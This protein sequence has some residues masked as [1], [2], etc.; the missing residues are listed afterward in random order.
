[1]AGGEFVRTPSL[2]VG[3]GTSRAVHQALSSFFSVKPGRSGL[4]FVLIHPEDPEAHVGV[5]SLSELIGLS[6]SIARDGDPIQ[7]DC[8]YLIP[9][10]STLTLESGVFRVAPADGDGVERVIDAF[11]HSLAEDRQAGAIGVVLS[12]NGSDGTLGLK[13]ISDAGGMTIVQDPATTMYDGMPRSGATLGMADRVLSPERMVPEILTYSNHLQS[14][15]VGDQ[16]GVVEEQIGGS[17]G[18]I[19]ELLESRTGHNFKHYKTST[20]ARRIGRRMQILRVQ[21]AESYLE[22]LE[23][24]PAEVQDLF[25]E[26]LICVTCFF[27]DP[28]S[29]ERLRAEVI[30]PLLKS[31][32]G[33]DPVRVWVPGCATGEEAYSLAILFREEMDRCPDPPPV[34]IFATDINARALARARQGA[35]PSSIADDLTPDRLS[36]FFEPAG[37]LLSVTR[38][39]REMCIFSQH[40]LIRDPPFSRLDLISCRNLLIY[41]GPHL[42]KKLIPLFHFA[43]RP[44]GYLFLGPAESL[45]DHPDLFKS[46]DSKHRIARRQAIAVRPHAS[47][48]R[49]ESARLTARGGTIAPAIPLQDLP[50]LMQRIVLDE[51]APRS[52]V[53]RDDGQIV[54]SSGGVERYLAIGEGVFQNDVVKLARSGLRLA[55]RSALAAAVESRRTVKN[56]EA[57]LR[58][59]E[60]AER[61]GLTIQPMPELGESSGLFLVVFQNLG[62]QADPGE[63]VL[64]GVDEKAN[65]LIEKLEQE[66]QDTR[67]DLE[68]TIQ[69]IGAANEE[70]KSAN[71][72]LLSMNEELQSTN[73]ELETSREEVQGANEALSRTNS[74][75]ENLLASTQIATIFV[76][77]E[78]KIERFTPSVVSIYN[79][80]ASDL[81]RPLTDIT[82][83]AESMPPLPSPESLLPGP[84]EDEIRTSDG[85]DFLRR[86]HPYRDNAGLVSGMVVT[87]IDITDRR[88]FEDRLRESESQFRTLAESIPQLAWIAAPDGDIF[89]FNRRWYE[90]TGTTPEQMEHGGW[91]M[92]H[93][94]QIL[95]SVIARW[96]GSLRTGEP[97]DM[98]FPIRRADG[99]FRSFLTRVEPIRDGAGRIVR[100]FGTNTDVEDQMRAEEELKQ[101]NYHKD[102]FLAILAHELR[103]PLSPIRNAVHLLRLTGSSEPTLVGAREM[104]D[105]QVTSLVRLVDDLMDVSRIN[106]GKVEL[107]RRPTDLRGVIESAVES[108]RPLVHS[109]GHEL[110][111]SLP[112][113]PFTADADAS[114]LAQVVLNLLNN[115]AKYTDEGG[116]IWVSLGREGP[117]GVIRV[118]DNGNG[119]SPELLPRVFEIYTQA[120]RT[121]DRSLGGLGIGLTIVRRLVEL[122]SGTVEARSDGPG[123]GSEFIVRLPLLVPPGEGNPAGE[124]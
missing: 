100:W 29:F 40:N 50:L 105:R 5:D 51:F 19:C 2:V 73:E 88:R 28:D 95:P 25:R 117:E 74:D 31:R 58:T 42:Q 39:I 61:V 108:A 114:R 97:F 21:S 102:E 54:C 98:V 60:G 113:E 22:R 16:G 109:K 35:Y 52:V 38:E 89:W 1:M 8:A 70:L 27:R 23:R 48:P 13:A 3:I 47:Q 110:S 124:S 103:N 68:R 32:G 67:L 115:S 101:A 123:R 119:L 84:R 46:L 77:R 43:L 111:V 87:F 104:I 57:V 69:E 15:L 92:V 96:E 93:D 30:G 94:P 90:Y 6:V 86:V 9:P 66:L 72:E 10:R 7:A 12:G 91:K 56:E 55:L 76:D 75:L 80:I 107:R 63:S 45:N 85:R 4:A 118:R 121:L 18:K 26:L 116:S 59:P 82:Y 53:V 11:F 79:L 44:G 71:E 112:N 99:M 49:S 36:R 37:R 106:R 122:H 65:T 17:L 83:R 34:Q 62:L 120:D 20:L 14:L 64:V 81:G 41:L 33:D 78:G 24:D